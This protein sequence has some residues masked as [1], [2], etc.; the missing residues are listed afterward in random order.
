MQMAL[1][2]LYPARGGEEEKGLCLSV[3]VAVIRYH[4]QMQLKEERGSFS[5]QLSGHPPS[6]GDIRAGTQRRK[7][8][9]GTEAEGMWSAFVACLAFFLIAPRLPAQGWW[10]SP[11]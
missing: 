7:L 6:L 5:L 2:L 11:Q 1:I 4:D 3:S 9:A 8:E 10:H